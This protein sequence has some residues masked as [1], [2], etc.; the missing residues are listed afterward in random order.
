MASDLM[1]RAVESCEALELNDPLRPKLL[2]LLGDVRSRMTE[3][4]ADR[5][6]RPPVPDKR[7]YVNQLGASHPRRPARMA[8]CDAVDQLLDHM[9]RPLSSTERARKRRRTGVIGPLNVR[10]RRKSKNWGA[11]PETVVH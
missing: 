11:G 3:T 8:A 9:W 6:R 10:K 1:Q 7:Q 5:G 2:E 4:R